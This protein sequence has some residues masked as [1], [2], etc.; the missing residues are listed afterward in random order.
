MDAQELIERFNAA[1]EAGDLTAVSACLADD[2]VYCPTAWDGP[3]A[4]VR[5]RAEVGK[6]FADQIGPGP[7]PVLGAVFAAGDRVVCEWQ[8]APAEDGTILRGLDLYQVRDGKIVA[9]DVHGKITI[10]RD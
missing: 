9:K 5:G 4:I 10:G 8:W 6:V 7:G 3:A 1:W 2:V